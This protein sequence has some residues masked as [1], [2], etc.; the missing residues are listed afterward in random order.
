MWSADSVQAP[1]PHADSDER[2]GSL[3]I[4]SAGVGAGH[5]SSAEGLRDELLYAAPGIHVRVRNGL[6][7]A[8]SPARVFLER[9]VRWQL[10]HCPPLYSVAYAIVVRSSVGRWL[11]LMTLHRSTRRR[12][13]ALIDSQQPSLVISTYPGIT[14]PLGVMRQRGELQI[15]VCALITDLT[16]LYFWAHPG[17]DLHLV[18][19]RQ[20]LEEVSRIAG[21]APVTAVKAPLRIAHWARRERGPTRLALGFDPR[22]A[23]VVISG[24]GWGVGDLNGS[25][26]GALG[27]QQVQVVVVCGENKSAARELGIRY[28]TDRRVRILGYT[29]DMAKLL[30]AASALVHST[31]GVSC[32]E[33]TA[34]GCPVVAYGFS[35]GHV[36]H[37]VKAMVELGLL[38]H[39]KNSSNLTLQL[40]EAIAEPQPPVSHTGDL[41]SAAEEILELIGGSEDRAEDSRT[42]R[43]AHRPRRRSAQRALGSYTEELIE[44]PRM[45]TL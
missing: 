43:H 2:P 24:G 18:S 10:M 1:T 44:R 11:A 29:D 23:L 8:G 37:N 7:S 38:R 25:I 35:C 40:K 4:L 42:A 41:R 17:V 15:P 13:A 16:S 9:L 45:S 33:A 12:L 28:Q 31:G 19:Y 21:A 26:R 3:L 34:H 30:A 32:L 27:L 20:S 5:Q 39:A 6:G 22:V 14:A 36:A